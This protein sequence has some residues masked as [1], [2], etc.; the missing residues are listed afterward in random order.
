[1]EGET[2]SRLESSIHGCPHSLCYRTRCLCKAWFSCSL[3]NLEDTY[4][5]LRVLSK[6]LRRN[7]CEEDT[8]ASNLMPPMMGVPRVFGRSTLRVF[9]ALANLTPHPTLNWL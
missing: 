3:N 2:Y 6:I 5:Q 7:Q 8:T 9:A 4:H 1:M